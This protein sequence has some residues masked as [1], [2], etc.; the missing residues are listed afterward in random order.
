[1]KKKYLFLIGLLFILFTSCEQ[2]NV[3]A[4]N[5]KD[6][7][8]AEKEPAINELYA[9]KGFMATNFS[10][11]SF[12]DKYKFK[13]MEAGTLKIKLNKESHTNDSICIG[14]D[15]ISGTSN[16]V[17][18]SEGTEISAILS[19]NFSR[20]GGGDKKDARYKLYIYLE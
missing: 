9:G 4:G 14:T 19:S 15:S 10:N 12:N 20:F 1:M 7:S 2:M 11:L 6:Y 18:V 8:D 13:V 17:E 16:T 5:I 3:P